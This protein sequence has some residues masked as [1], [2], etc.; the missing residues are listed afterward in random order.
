MDLRFR[1]ETTTRDPF[2]SRDSSFR[3][4]PIG[5]SRPQFFPSNAA[6]TLVAAVDP[7]FGYNPPPMEL[8]IERAKAGDTA[9]MEQLLATVA[10]A[11]QRFGIRMCRNDDDAEDVLQDALLTIANHLGEFEGRSSF[12]SWAFTLA[13]SACSRKRRGLKNQPHLSLD[14][15]VNSHEASP[16]PEQQVADREMA[17]AL[18]WAL[19]RLPEDYREVIL[20]RDVE[21]LTAPET[22]ESLGISVEA[23]K[24][25]LHRARRAL[26]DA[27]KPVLE[28]QPQASPAGCPDVLALWSRKLEGDLSHLDCAEMEKHMEKCPA[29]TSA[30]SA[31]KAALFACQRVRSK[32]V[33]PEVQSQIRAAV[34]KWVTHGTVA[35]ADT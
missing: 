16:T 14:D 18:N 20:L 4:T 28:P 10:P 12:S 1:A 27:L 19:D 7:D 22:A 17:Q 9:A 30:C 33:G 26:R 25:R 21:D 31:L 8:L 29:C 15:T 34:Q 32:D 24:S 3:K 6:D 23:V 2:Q 5:S 11:I 35:G 13:R